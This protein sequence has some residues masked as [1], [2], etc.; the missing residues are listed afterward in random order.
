MRVFTSSMGA[1]AP[2]GCT[3]ATNPAHPIAALA[4]GCVENMLSRDF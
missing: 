3:A 4:E 1:L 2:S